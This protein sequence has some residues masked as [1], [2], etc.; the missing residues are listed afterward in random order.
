MSLAHWLLAYCHTLRTIL[1]LT[2]FIRTLDFTDRLFAFDFAN[3]IFGFLTHGVAYRGFTDGF[4][5]FLNLII[6]PN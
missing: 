6:K 4:T 2:G 1:C 5:N 3:C